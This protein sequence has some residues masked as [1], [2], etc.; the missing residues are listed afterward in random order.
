M[1]YTDPDFVGHFRA[2]LGKPKEEPK[3]LPEEPMEGRHEIAIP[4]FN[5]TVEG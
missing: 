5:E 2:C 4:P 3:P 1:N